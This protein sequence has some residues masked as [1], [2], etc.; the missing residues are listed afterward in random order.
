MYKNLDLTIFKQSKWP[1]KSHFV[2]KRKMLKPR[3][4]RTRVWNLQDKWFLMVSFWDT[5][6]EYLR[7]AVIAA[8]QMGTRRCFQGW[9]GPWE[10]ILHGC[11]SH[12]Q[13]ICCGALIYFYPNTELWDAK[14]PV[15]FQW[16]QC[17]AWNLLWLLN[18]LGRK[19]SWSWGLMSAS[20]A[21]RK[22]W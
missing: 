5:F 1:N 20:T 3:L 13:T 18:N 22:S 10:G 12:L 16:I 21:R 19:R 6:N 4:G 15:H 17:R 2:S 14:I 9:L 7:S 8:T 11:R